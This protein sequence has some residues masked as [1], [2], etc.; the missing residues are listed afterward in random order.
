MLKTGEGTTDQSAVRELR[1]E[2]T[3]TTDTHSFLTLPQVHILN[4]EGPIDPLT[5][6]AP[7]KIFL[8]GFLVVPHALMS[9]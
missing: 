6:A 4:L 1:S 7:P 9:D 3:P 5:S 8:I 2:L